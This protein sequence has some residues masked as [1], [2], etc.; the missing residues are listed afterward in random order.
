VHVLKKHQKN[1]MNW[2]SIYEGC[3]STSI[4]VMFTWGYG[5]MVCISK[6]DAYSGCVMEGDQ[7][8]W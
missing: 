1:K 6:I 5:S 3:V 4:A 8:S 2:S 7:N